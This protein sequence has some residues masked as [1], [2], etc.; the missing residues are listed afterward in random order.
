MDRLPPIR[1]TERSRWCFSAIAIALTM[2]CARAGSSPVAQQRMRDSGPLIRVLVRYHA[3]HHR[4]PDSLATLAA[5]DLTG[6]DSAAASTIIE[7]MQN[8][9]SF[10]DAVITYKGSPSTYR[11]EF[12]AGPD[13]CSYVPAHAKWRCTGV[14]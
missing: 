8:P 7:R 2:A 9:A 6:P 1:L 13:F 5:G 11:L 12:R 3:S 14:I 4:Y 10:K